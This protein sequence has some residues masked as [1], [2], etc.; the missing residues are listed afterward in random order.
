[1]RAA[2]AMGP[3]GGSPRRAGWAPGPFG[4][5]QCRR[6]HRQAA[7]GDAPGEE[8]RARGRRNAVRSRVDPDLLARVWVGERIAV[9]RWWVEQES[10]YLSAEE[11]VRMLLDLAV[12]GRYSASGFE[13]SA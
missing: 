6:L 2:G 1:M 5:G 7:P 4:G 10:P 12:R 13:P 11:V 8:F 3:V 9:L